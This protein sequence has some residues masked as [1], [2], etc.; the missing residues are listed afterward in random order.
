MAATTQVRLLVVVIA[1][2]PQRYAT[3]T[4]CQMTG[5]DA[6]RGH[7]YAFQTGVQ[8]AGAAVRAHMASFSCPLALEVFDFFRCPWGPQSCQ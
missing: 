7:A 2:A 6:W 1:G 5:F 4:A 8:T 3:R